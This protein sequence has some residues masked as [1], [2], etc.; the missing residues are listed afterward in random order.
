MVMMMSVSG[1]HMF[2]R[3]VGSKADHL[4]RAKGASGLFQSVQAIEHVGRKR[5][6][7]ARARIEFES[8]RNHFSIWLVVRADKRN[9]SRAIA[10]PEQ[11]G[12]PK[13][14]TGSANSSHAIG[15][16]DFVF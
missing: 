4:R 8:A 11:S 3:A 14:I 6:Q 10:D 7:L 15:Q 12:H 13:V 1:G 9:N 16:F 2:D 5:T